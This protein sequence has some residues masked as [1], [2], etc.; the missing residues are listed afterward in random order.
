MYNG[1]SDLI[2]AIINGITTIKKNSTNNDQFIVTLSDNTELIFDNSTHELRLLKEYK[3]VENS[4]NFTI[5]ISNDSEII[6]NH[7]DL[8]DTIEEAVT[9]ST[10][11]KEVFEGVTPQITDSSMKYIVNS[12]V[13]E[14][15]LDEL[16]DYASDSGSD[17]LANFINAIVDNYNAENL[18]CEL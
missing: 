1:N 9:K 7:N 8:K 4:N 11:F 2:R 16:A 17:I 5:T 10:A 6:S 13:L 18:N 3:P 12:V 14:A 15:N